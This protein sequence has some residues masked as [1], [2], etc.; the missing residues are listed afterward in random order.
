MSSHPSRFNHSDSWGWRHVTHLLLRRL[1]LLLV[2]PLQLAAVLLQL[3]LLRLPFQESTVPLLLPQ[4]HHVGQLLLVVWASRPELLADARQLLLQIGD[5]LVRDGQAR[6]VHWVSD[7]DG[8]LNG[9]RPCGSKA[10]GGELQQTACCFSANFGFD[11]WANKNNQYSYSVC[12]TR[13]SK[14]R[15]ELARWC[16]YHKSQN[17]L[18]DFWQTTWTD[19]K[20]YFLYTFFLATPRHGLEWWEVLWRKVLKGF[21]FRFPIS[22]WKLKWYSWR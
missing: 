13:A 10:R 22:L 18:S 19:Y 17:A 12:K 1:P 7:V 16:H 20:W 9:V 2:A 5:P 4:L 21:I 15:L 3:L 14:W 11:G 6:R 8:A